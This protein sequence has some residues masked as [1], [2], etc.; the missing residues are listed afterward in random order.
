[1]R[2]V[3]TKCSEAIQSAVYQTATMN[4]KCTYSYCELDRNDRVT[5]MRDGTVKDRVSSIVMI[6]IS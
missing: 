3:S 4:M 2:R 1:M 5:V 6:E